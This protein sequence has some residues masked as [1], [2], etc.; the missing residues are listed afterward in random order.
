MTGVVLY[1]LII[2]FA[3]ALAFPAIAGIGSQNIDP[4]LMKAYVFSK[5]M[6][7][8]YH[9]GYVK[10]DE[11][12]VVY[13]RDGEVFRKRFRAVWMSASGF[14]IMYRMRM[15]VSAGT[16]YFENGRVSFLPVTGNVVVEMR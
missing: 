9:G 10:V 15:I 6:D 13:L 16:V 8:R 1:A 5:I 7:S 11:N 4:I 14:N 2:L 3:F 12:G